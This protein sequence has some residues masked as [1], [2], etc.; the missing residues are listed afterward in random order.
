MPLHIRS[1]R[2]AAVSALRLFNHDEALRAAKEQQQH[3][4]SQGGGG[5]GGAA[6]KENLAEGGAAGAGAEGGRGGQGSTRAVVGLSMATA[7]NGLELELLAAQRTRRQ[8]QA[9]VRV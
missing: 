2:K 1:L 9:E 5:A 7:L 3:E 6:E 8:K 4:A